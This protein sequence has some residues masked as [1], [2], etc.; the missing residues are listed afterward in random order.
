ML[1]KT[2]KK[3]TNFNIER[4]MEKVYY[5]SIKNNYNWQKKS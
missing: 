3:R 1:L 2:K 4:M 5:D